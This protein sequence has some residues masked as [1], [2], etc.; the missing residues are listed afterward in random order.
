MAGQTAAWWFGLGPQSDA[1]GTDHEWAERV[2][3]EL[4]PGK[5]YLELSKARIAAHGLIW[6]HSAA[7]DR[8]ARELYATRY[9]E[10]DELRHAIDRDFGRHTETRD[11][12]AFAQRRDRFEAL[13]QAEREAGREPD[14]QAIWDAVDREV[15]I[16]GWKPTRV[17]AGRTTGPRRTTGTAQATRSGATSMR[18][19]PVEDPVQRLRAS[20]LARLVNPRIL[21]AMTAPNVQ[22]TSEQRGYPVI[23]ARRLMTPSRWHA[24]DPSLSAKEVIQ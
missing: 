7:V 22:A 1:T 10:G 14:H 9:L 13:V 21:A 17:A 3:G 4:N 19:S 15:L 8:F 20:V 6:D 12:M 11:E 24:A 2:A 18:R 23:S 16:A 5:P